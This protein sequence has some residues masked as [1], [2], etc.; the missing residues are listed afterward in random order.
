[1]AM[2]WHEGRRF[3]GD[4][5]TLPFN[6][7]GLLLGD[8]LFETMLVHDANIWRKAEHLQRL[9]DSA[10]ALNMPLDDR[11]EQ[12]LA[13]LAR[14]AGVGCW[15]LR[16]TVTRGP[17]ERGL[18][19]PAAPRPEVFASMVPWRLDAGGPLRLV[20]SDIRRNQ[21]SPQSRHKTLGYLDNILALEAALKQGSDDALLLNSQGRLACTSAGNIFA[22]ANDALLTP[23][24][25]D[26][27]LSGI[28]RRAIMETAPALGLAVREQS[29]VIAALHKARSVFVVNSLRLVQP[30]L[31]LD[32]QMLRQNDLAAK[33][34]DRLLAEIQ[35]SPR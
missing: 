15:A 4:S 33:L 30:V 7:R 9:K 1:M 31:S 17:G 22:L 35:S 21:T 24:L 18:R 10:L 3:E 28:T 11:P 14:V 23:P 12:A 2:L 26:G 20:V 25:S 19:M 13:D 6:D 8:G 34:N 27:V 16:L 29:L 5:F 32:G